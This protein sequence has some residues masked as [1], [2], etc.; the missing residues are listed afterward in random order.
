MNIKLNFKK[1]KKTMKKIML[2][3]ALCLCLPAMA[4]STD[5]TFVIKKLRNN[6]GT[7]VVSIYD[8][9]SQWNDDGKWIADCLNKE[10]IANNQTRVVCNLAPGTYAAAPFHDENNN[11]E[12]DVN[13]LGMPK[14]GYGYSNDAKGGAGWPLY[15]DAEFTVG[16]EDKELIIHMSY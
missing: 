7:V 16:S 4:F 13:F 14:E 9:A 10:P 3:A 5:V 2:I 11:N 12:F 1:E 6:N 8:D 15:K